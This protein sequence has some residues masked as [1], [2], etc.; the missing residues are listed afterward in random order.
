[1]TDLGKLQAA[2]EA[3]DSTA[4]LE[5]MRDHLDAKEARP[6]RMREIIEMQHSTLLAALTKPPRPSTQNDSL[7][8][9]QAATG[10]LKGRWICDELTIPRVEDESLGAWFERVRFMVR[11]VNKEL[12]ELNAEEL[13]YKLEASVV[14]GQ[15]KK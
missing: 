9:K 15:A 5:A 14:Q 3:G 7:S 8:F 6:P 11:E 13:R 1:M 12:I 10:D 4:A 2:L